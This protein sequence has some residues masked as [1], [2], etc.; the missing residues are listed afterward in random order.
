META[1]QKLS[2]WE[3]TIQKQQVCQFLPGKQRGPEEGK[4]S[5]AAMAAK[6]SAEEE[7]AASATQG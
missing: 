1:L 6:R 2:Q 5:I 7:P 4:G 3:V